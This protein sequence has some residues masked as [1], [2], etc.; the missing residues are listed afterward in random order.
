MAG[1]YFNACRSL[2]RFIGIARPGGESTFENDCL[3]VLTVTLDLVCL[4][5]RPLASTLIL[6]RSF[7]V[8]GLSSLL[9]NE[10]A[11]S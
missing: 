10:T 1:K 7:L 5:N 11:F 3:I 2:A 6:L 9:Q 8:R 4:F